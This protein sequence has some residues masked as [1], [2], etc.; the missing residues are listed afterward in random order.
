MKIFKSQEVIYSKSCPEALWQQDCRLVSCENLKQTTSVKHD[1]KLRLKQKPA[2]KNAC[3][4]LTE[5]STNC[6]APL[7][8]ISFAML[9]QNILSNTCAEYSAGR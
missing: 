3:S 8:V 1:A 2:H 6:N 4:Y 5:I 7:S 9:Q